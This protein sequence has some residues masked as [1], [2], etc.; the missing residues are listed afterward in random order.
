MMAGIFYLAQRDKRK[1]I[2]PASIQIE[3]IDNSE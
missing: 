2:A 1:E 3:I